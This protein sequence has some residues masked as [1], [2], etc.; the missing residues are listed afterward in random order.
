M[1]GFGTIFGSQKKTKTQIFKKSKID[2]KNRFFPKSQK[3]LVVTLL[4]HRIDFWRVLHPYRPCFSRFSR[5]LNLH[6]LDLVKF[7]VG[8]L[9]N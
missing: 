2:R 6:F 1:G 3:L 4:V 7:Q 5:T 8:G 9:K